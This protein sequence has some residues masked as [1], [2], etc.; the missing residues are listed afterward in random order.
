MSHPNGTRAAD[1]GPVTWRRPA[2][3]ADEGQN[4]EFAVLDDGQVAVRNARDPEG[5]VLVYTPAEISAFVDGAK[6]GEFDDM[7]DPFRD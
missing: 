6:K 2:G 1:L 3:G 5:P 7:V 4:V